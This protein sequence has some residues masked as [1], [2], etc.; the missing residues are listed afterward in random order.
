MSQF[1]L[2]TKEGLEQAR[3]QLAEQR[4]EGA[5]SEFYAA[6]DAEQDTEAI[7]DRL[8]E[9]QLLNEFASERRLPVVQEAPTREETD[10]Y[11]P[12]FLIDGWMPANRLTMLTGPEARASLTLRCSM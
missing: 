5:I 7:E 12:E 1:N 6:I 3:R 10:A 8:K 4:R 9:I 11:E 2:K